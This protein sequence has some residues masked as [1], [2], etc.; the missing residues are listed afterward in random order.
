MTFYGNQHAQHPDVA[1]ARADLVQHLVSTHKMALRPGTTKAS[2]SA[3]HIQAHADKH[4]GPM[5]NQEGVKRSVSTDERQSLASSGHTFQSSNGGTSYPIANLSDLDHAIQ[6]YGR[7]PEPDR[8]AL[9]RYLA[10]EAKRLNASQD[11]LDRIDGLGES[12]SEGKAFPAAF[13]TAI[14][15]IEQ[16]QPLDAAAVLDTVH[17]EGLKSIA[18]SAAL[19]CEAFEMTGNRDHLQQALILLEGSRPL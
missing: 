12:E 8:P 10:K 3:L 6:S 16:G 18:A 4:G 14:A 9:K 19:S 7:C 11:V 13:G 2:L 17:E 5:V 15:L 1:L